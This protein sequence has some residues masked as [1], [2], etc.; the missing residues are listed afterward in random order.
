MKPKNALELVEE[1]SG[2]GSVED[3][4]SK[5][6]E[7][8]RREDGK[9]RAYLTVNEGAVEEARKLEK[10]IRKGRRGSLLGV[11]IA[12]KDNISTEGLRTTCASRML[13]NYVPPYDAEVISRIKKEGGIILGKTNMDEFAMGSS[14]EFSAFGPT[15]NPFD[16]SRVPGGSSGGSG[17]ALAADLST[18]ALG[19]DTG[20]SIRCPSAFTSTFGLKPTYGMV[21]RYGLVAY[22]NS[23][24]QIGPMG[25]SVE[26]V[27]LLFQVISGRDEKD[28]TSVEAPKIDY[29]EEARKGAKGFKVGVLKEL[30]GEGVDGHVL[31]AFW[32]AVHRLEGEGVEYD[33]VSIKYLDY[34]LASYYVIAMAEASSNLARFDGMR[35]GL[36]VRDQG[37][38]EA[39]FSKNRSEGFGEEVKRRIILGTFVLS[40]GYYEEYY[41]KAQKVRRL[42]KESFDRLFKGYDLLLSPTMPTLP[43]RIGEKQSPL[44]MYLSDVATVPA[45][46]V[47]IPSLSVPIGFYDGL[48]IGLQAMAPEFG[49]AKA[50]R[51]GWELERIG[52]VP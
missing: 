12:V 49:E 2:G 29:V 14:T 25:R 8:I 39:I 22:A 43:W 51:L 37:N 41:L 35:Y 17:A 16:L 44:E 33:E 19:S 27:A 34:A 10:E 32:D 1:F 46:L 38:W 3:Y 24:E 7:R 5:L 47:G 45:N 20:G 6:I 30:T 48:P 31:K 26:D 52:V 50:F 18:L 21:S 11:G 4:I 40:A 42:L 9:I 28:S 36:R 23:L 15:R 13:E